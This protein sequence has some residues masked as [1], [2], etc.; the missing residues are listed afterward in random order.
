MRKISYNKEKI[1]IDQGIFFARGVFETILW[2]RKPI[3]LT[4]HI[5]R[6]KKGMD[7]IG[8][9]PLEEK[10]LIDFLKSLHIKNK[11]IKI[12]ITPLNIIINERELPYK[13]EDYNNGFKLTFSKVRRNS[14][15]NLTYIKSTG[16][17][18]NLL[19]KEKAIKKGYNDTIFLN[20]KGYITETSCSNIFIIKNNEIFTPRVQDG[21]L[22]G[23]IRRWIVENNKV[24]VKSLTI[25][26]I[27]ECDEIFITNSLMGI[28]PVV[29][30]DNIKYNKTNYTSRIRENFNEVM[31]KLGGNYKW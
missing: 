27:R 19:E 12:I 29:E 20:E 2:A 9:E 6:L 23:I 18:E 11:G 21:L 8:L 17:I 7:I 28:M 13:K 10:V 25:K 30:I 24:I 3:L 22:N 31:A 15:S 5:D 14:T 4:E 1:L 26:D 16:Y